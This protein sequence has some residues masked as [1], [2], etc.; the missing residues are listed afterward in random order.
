MIGFLKKYIKIVHLL[1]MTVFAKFP[2]EHN[3]VMNVFVNIWVEV[4]P[5]PPVYYQRDENF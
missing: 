5:P 4:H 3:I 1:F 2:T